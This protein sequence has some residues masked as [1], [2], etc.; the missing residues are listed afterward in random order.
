MRP[1]ARLLLP[2]LLL[3]AAVGCEW[4]EKMKSSTKDGLTRPGGPVKST[5]APELVG[6]L[7]GRAAAQLSRSA[8]R[9]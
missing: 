2:A 4:M 3:A 7:N 5:T 6:Y 8:T 9:T 1:V